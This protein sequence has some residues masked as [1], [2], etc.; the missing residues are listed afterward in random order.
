MSSTNVLR[1][2]SV[3]A[4]RGKTSPPPRGERVRTRVYLRGRH[5]NVNMS[6]QV[7]EQLYGKTLRIPFPNH[8]QRAIFPHCQSI[9]EC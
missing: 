3:N 2:V 6:W 7:G 8:R 5:V 9:G 4:L 1:A